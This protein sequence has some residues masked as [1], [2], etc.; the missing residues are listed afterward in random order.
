MD[1]VPIAGMIFSLLCLMTIGGF[2]LLFP[3]TMRLG[4]VLEQWLADRKLKQGENAELKALRE[5]VQGLEA[6]VRRL[7]ERQAFTDQVLQP[8]PP[9]SGA[10]PAPGDV[11]E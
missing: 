7:A 1:I 2:I 3:V 4:K 11:N 8:P 10:L 6:E 9:E 5:T